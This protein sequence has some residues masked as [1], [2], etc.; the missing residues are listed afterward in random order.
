MTEPPPS[1]SLPLTVRIDRHALGAL[2]AIVARSEVDR[3]TATAA[4]LHS[5]ARL[6]A[7]AE[8]PVE[9]QQ[10]RVWLYPGQETWPVW[11]GEL[12]P[13]PRPV[14]VRR[15]GVAWVAVLAAL[16]VGFVAGALVA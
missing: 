16:A 15:P 2:D 8:L 13:A 4:A 9:R 14:W 1:T 6:L 10:T 11:V 12:P 5:H 7:A 3:D